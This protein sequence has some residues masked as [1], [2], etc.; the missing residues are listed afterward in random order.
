VE[1]LEHRWCP[2]YSLVTSRTALAGTDSINWGTPGPAGTVV[3]NPFTILST[4]GRSITVS[5]PAVFGGFAVFEQTPPTTAASWNGNFA[6]GD[7]LLYGGLRGSK[8][9]DPYTLNFGSAAVAAAGAQIES[10]YDGK[11]TAQVQ[12]LDANGNVLASFTE[13][14]NATQAAD[15]SAIF[16]GISSTSANIYQI[17]LSLTKAPSNTIGDFA[18]NEFDFRTSPLAAGAPAATSASAGSADSLYIGDGSDNTIKQFDATTGAYEGTLVTSGSQGLLGP[19]GLIFR[20]D[21]QL[22]VVNQNVGL[23]TNGAVLRYNGQTGVPLGALVPAS[24]PNAPFAPRGMVLGAN[25]TLYVADD[26]NLDGITLGRLARFNSETGAFLGDL[27]PTGFSG[28]FYPRADVLGP[29]GL[30]YVSVRNIAP[31]GGEVMRWDPATGDYLGSFITGN[32][33]NDL[34]RPEGLAFG[35]DGNLSHV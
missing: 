34:N 20:N 6:P 3:S 11:F 15:N 18:I 5:Q 22:L 16:I 14:G 10:D 1:Q 9:S 28:D 17:A 30:L 29:D 7:L 23:P 12:A 13:N 26:G 32:A 19:R 24:D 31:T 2:S 35:P 27:E 4:G 33:T 21:G 8:K 25:H